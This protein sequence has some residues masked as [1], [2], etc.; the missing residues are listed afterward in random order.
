VTP[1]QAMLRKSSWLFGG[2]QGFT[3]PS[4]WSQP[5]VMLSDAPVGF[6]ETIG[7]SFDEYATKAFKGSSPV[8]SAIQARALPFS[9][10][11]FQYQR[12][13]GG[14]PGELF[15]DGSLSMLHA[16]W[17]NG[18]TGEMLARMEQ[19]ASLA[20]NS[21]WTPINGRLRRMR[22]DWVTILSGVRGDATASPFSLEAEVLG[23]IY[24]PQA[25]PG[26]VRPA[27]VLLLPAQVVHYSPIPDPL[28]QW[29]GMSWLTPVL[30]E[31]QGDKAAM[32]HKLQYFRNG[33]TSGMVVTYDKSIGPDMYEEYVSLFSKTY[34]GTDKAYKTIH[35]G[36]GA[37]AKVLGADLK[38]L[39]FKVVQGHGETRIAAAAGVGAIIARFSEGM[40]GS[41]LNAGN[42]SAAKRQ[43]ADMTL[44][45]LWRIAAAS[46]AKPVITRVP[47]SCRLWYDDR[48]VAF[49]K[50]DAKDEA[51]IF[52]V[53]AAAIRA[54]TDGGYTPESVVAA[55]AARNPTLL[56]HTGLYPVQVQPPTTTPRSEA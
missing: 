40:Q 1:I 23:Y 33:T 15:D 56:A 16:P 44:R 45:P 32:K 24:H 17:I 27:P 12:L 49:L 55:V 31:I 34:Q 7:S 51:D 37:D 5:E 8:F 13:D 2:G 4:F 29:R 54:L 14:R 48:D 11:R 30:D 47:A 43:F 50:E 53:E 18:T 25:A 39:D 46:L 21:Y 42:Y 22:P 20:G 26:G 9:E 10:A 28:A 6:K 38:Q 41:S 36:G 52:N 19:D 35:L 3:E